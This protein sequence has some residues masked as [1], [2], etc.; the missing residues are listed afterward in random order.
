MCIR[1]RSTGE[2]TSA[3]GKR[4]QPEYRLQELVFQARDVFS[5]LSKASALLETYFKQNGPVPRLRRESKKRKKARESN[6]GVSNIVAEDAN[7]DEG[8]EGEDLAE[9]EEVV[10]VD[11]AA[12]SDDA[13]EASGVDE[14]DEED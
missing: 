7:E 12:E 9:T 14:R 6:E 10:D 5:N 3:M 1:D 11:V 4:D 13:A 8:V 2:L